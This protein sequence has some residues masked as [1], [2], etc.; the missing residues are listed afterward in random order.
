MI[1]SNQAAIIAGTNS[2]YLSWIASI[3]LLVSVGNLLL[4]LPQYQQLLVHEILRD[5]T[6]VIHY[7]Q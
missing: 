2:K 3:W 7:R 5:V 6:E 1:V 4:V